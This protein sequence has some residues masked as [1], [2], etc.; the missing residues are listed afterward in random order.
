MNVGR[1]V[2]YDKPS[3]SVYLKKI[4]VSFLTGQLL[5][6]LFKLLAYYCVNHSL[7]MREATIGK[8][9][10]I[11]ASV[12][13][14]QSKNII[15]GNHC[16]INHNNVLQAGKVDAKIIIGDYVH[17]GA[18]V[19]IIAFNH[20][21]DS[22]DIPTIEQDYYDATIE[23]GDDVWIGGGSIILA[24]VKIGKGA[25]IAA[26]AVVNKDVPDYAIVGGVPAKVLKYRTKG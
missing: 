1:K 23:I 18:N 4:L 2:H 20:G 15:I 25:I 19:M 7:G 12:I 11:H 10:N 9:T 5:K 8:N 14:R 13:L 22:M 21:F 3:R 24:G 6:D 16:L 17:T 26:G